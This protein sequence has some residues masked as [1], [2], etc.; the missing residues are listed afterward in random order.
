MTKEKWTPTWRL[1]LSSLKWLFMKGKHI[2][3][4]SLDLFHL[5]LKLDALQFLLKRLFILKRIHKK[6]TKKTI[7]WK[8]YLHLIFKVSSLT[9]NI[10]WVG[11]LSFW[12]YNLSK[13]FIRLAILLAIAKQAPYI[14]SDFFV[15][16]EEIISQILISENLNFTI[17]YSKMVTDFKDIGKILFSFFFQFSLKVFKF[18]AVSAAQQ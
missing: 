13:Q 10:I 4:S 18:W 11:K 14:S 6:S 3:F 2:S 7:K 15:F 16:R 17:S 9:Q 1:V 8:W 5:S 12:S